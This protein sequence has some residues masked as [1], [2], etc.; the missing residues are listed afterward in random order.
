[1]FIKI[2]GLSTPD[3][4]AAAIEAGADALGFVLAPN[5]PRTITPARARELIDGVPSSIETVGVFRNQPLTDVL[6]MAHESGVRTVQLHGDEPV[7]DAEAVRE[8]GFD[9]L[10]AFSANAFAAMD[11]D[12]REYWAAK[13]ILLDA[14]L[15][16]EGIPFDASVLA[17]ARP[18][19]FW[20]LAG[21]LTPENVA[22]LVTELEPSG[23][24]VSS[25]VESS[26]GVKSAELIAQFVRAVRP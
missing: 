14:P 19:G 21:G 17:A 5:S 2:C 9:L 25:G 7:S 6:A 3:T 22:A 26:R 13:R 20:L 8:A 4:V 12:D 23:V 10:R 16:G 18:S 11:P 15:P 24:D 1:M